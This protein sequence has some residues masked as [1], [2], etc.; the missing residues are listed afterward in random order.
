[1]ICRCCCDVY[2]STPG[3]WSC[4]CDTFL[5]DLGRCAT[6]HQVRKRIE[7]R[8]RDLHQSLLVKL[9]RAMARAHGKAGGIEIQGAPGALGET[10]ALVQACA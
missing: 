4:S 9:S 6:A 1:M 10:G 7:C 5:H 3:M 2:N 8:T